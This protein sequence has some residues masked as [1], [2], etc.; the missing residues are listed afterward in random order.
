M[1]GVACA[2]PRSYHPRELEPPIS[3]RP[4]APLIL[5]PARVRCGLEGQ[6]LILL[7]GPAAERLAPVL[8]PNGYVATAPC[9]TLAS[10]QAQLSSCDRAFLARGDDSEPTRSAGTKQRPSPTVTCS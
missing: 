5:W 6:I 1:A 4:E 3:R 9:E 8:R 7:A 10:K 2:G